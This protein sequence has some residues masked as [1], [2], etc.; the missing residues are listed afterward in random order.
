MKKLKLMEATEKSLYKGIEQAVEGN[1]LNDI[2]C[3]VQ[4]FIEGS[5]F[6]VVRDLCGH[7]IGK[8]L[9]EDPA[10]LNYYSAGNNKKPY[11]GTILAI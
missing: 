5:G 4:N 1:T 7:G 8:N 9:H 2:A 3:A 11:S 10:V 6:G